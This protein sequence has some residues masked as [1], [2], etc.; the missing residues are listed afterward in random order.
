MRWRVPKHK[1]NNKCRK[2]A[3]LLLAATLANQALPAQSVSYNQSLLWTRYYVRLNTGERQSFHA[4]IDNRCFF[5]PGAHQHQFILHAHYH[6]PFIKQTEGWAGAS[7][8]RVSAQR[9]ELTDQFTVPEY[10]LW[11]AVSHRYQMPGGVLN[12]RL[13]W[14]ERFIHQGNHSTLQPGFRF[15]FRVRYM[16]MAQI[17]LLHRLDL[18]IGDE[19]MGQT[20]EGVAQFFDQNR[21]WAGLDYAISRK[22]NIELLYLWLWQQSSGVVSFDRDILRLTLS[23]TIR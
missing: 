10:R 5:Q 11:Q 9:P 20:G 17:P 14:E 22:V 15:V 3:G 1:G 6:F 12:Q 8:S 19:V 21:L 13:R 4:E 18:K 23:Q 2:W 7:W 16:L